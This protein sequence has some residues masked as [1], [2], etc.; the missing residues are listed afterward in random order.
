MTVLLQTRVEQSVAENFKR[1]AKL[2]G[3]TPYAYLQQMVKQAAVAPEPRTW[4]NHWKLIQDLKLTPV[5]YNI[6]AKMR[7]EADER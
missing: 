3:K 2:R 5:P 4:K 1:A 7:E 6:V